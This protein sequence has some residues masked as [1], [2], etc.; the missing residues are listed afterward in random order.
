MR[1]H[2]AEQPK[3]EKNDQNSSENATTDIHVSLR[4]RY[5]DRIQYRWCGSVWA[6]P[7][8]AQRIAEQGI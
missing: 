6:L 5:V 4:E 8:P 1:S 7:H 2:P 3:N